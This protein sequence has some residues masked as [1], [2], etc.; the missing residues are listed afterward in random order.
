MLTKDEIENLFLNCKNKTDL[1]NKLNIPTNKNG[2][3]I[4]NELL[5]YL[6]QIGFSDRNSISKVNFNKE[7]NKRKE[8]FYLLNP[9]ICPVC[10]KNIPWEKHNNKCCCQSCSASYSNKKRGNLS[11][12]TKQKI[13]KGLHKSIL[14]GITKPK[15]QYT[16]NALVYYDVN[17]N[18]TLFFVLKDKIRFINDIYC[19]TQYCIDNGYIKND[20]QY[21]FKENV[22]NTFLYKKQICKNCGKEF[23]GRVTK[24]GN[25]S[26]TKTCSSKCESE[27]RSKQS[28]NLI[29]K[30][31]EAGTFQ[32]WK[33]RNNRSYAEKFW[34][35]VLNNNNI[36]FVLEYP[37][38]RKGTQNY[39]LD[40]YI[41]KNGKKIDLEIDGKQHKYPDRKEQDKLRD[42]YL[43]NLG[44]IVYRIEWNKMS[45]KQEESDLTKEK[46]DKF[47]NFYDSL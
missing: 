44:Y 3:W 24:Y 20:E 33:P 10:G 39:F 15:N 43:T 46:I 18:T 21:N 1:I 42:E 30:Q 35:N 38:E 6:R 27:N 5:F 40:F 31:I 14:N 11:E 41:E 4:D 2:I 37:I 34:I 17:D 13:S 9:K 25:I 28:K 16:K 45:G 26:N 12:E 47:L 23:F 36:S 19:D 32:G 8:K 29:A 7:L 22:I